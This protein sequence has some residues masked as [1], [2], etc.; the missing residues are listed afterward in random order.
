M[1]G[2]S[3]PPGLSLQDDLDDGEG[4]QE[5]CAACV[6]PPGV[7]APSCP[8]GMFAPAGPPGVFFFADSGDESTCSSPPGFWEKDLDGL[9]FGDL[10]TDVESDSEMSLEG[11]FCD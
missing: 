7:F 11:S 3:A 8:P 5:K 2:L 4:E 6:K 9:T 1:G 10:S